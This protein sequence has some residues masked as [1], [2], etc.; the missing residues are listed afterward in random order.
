MR[1]RVRKTKQAKGIKTADADGRLEVLAEDIRSGHRRCLESLKGVVA[2][3][4]EIGQSLVEAKGLVK[5][6]DWLPWV[7]SHCHFAPRMAQNYMLVAKH[8]DAV[9]ARFELADAWRLTEFIAVA[10]EL[11]GNRRDKLRNKKGPAAV[12]RPEP[13]LAAPEEV[14]RRRLALSEAKRPEVERLQRERVISSFVRERLEALYA[15]VRRFT[16]SKSAAAHAGTAFDEPDLGIILV[17]SLQ[18]ALDPAGLFDTPAAPAGSQG[19]P[20]GNPP[21][22]TLMNGTAHE[23]L[24]T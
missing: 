23:L 16:R 17:E 9:V 3:A 20:P 24:L 15:A 6:G 5:H 14:E 8:Y 19:P 11:E 13:F 12:A 21:E 18:E 22:V 1:K 4:R 10:R 2:Q 7:E